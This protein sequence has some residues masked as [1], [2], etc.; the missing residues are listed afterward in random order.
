MLAYWVNLVGGCTFIYHGGSAYISHHLTEKKSDYIKY[1]FKSLWRSIMNHTPFRQYMS[2]VNVASNS[3]RRAKMPSP[4][5]SEWLD[6]LDRV[7]REICWSV[8]ANDSRFWCTWISVTCLC[9]RDLFMINDILLGSH[10]RCRYNIAFVQCIVHH[11]T[12]QPPAHSPPALGSDWNSSTYCESSI[13]LPRACTLLNTSTLPMLWSTTCSCNFS[14][15]VTPIFGA[16]NT[17]KSRICA[18]DTLCTYSSICVCL[19]SRPINPMFC[20]W[21]QTICPMFCDWDQTTHAE[22]KITYQIS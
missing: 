7:R 6:G 1:L 10:R 19:K 16:V 8:F 4:D 12:H 11:S 9:W 18:D 15:R 5:Q 2:F 13:D 20:D 3:L 22:P 21:D 14:F 17:F